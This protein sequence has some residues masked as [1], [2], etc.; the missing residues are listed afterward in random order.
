MYESLFKLGVGTN[1]IEGEAW[2]I[3]REKMSGP[4]GDR[5]V[6][7]TRKCEMQRWT[8]SEVR[9]KA[10][11]SLNQCWR[12]E[13]LVRRLVGL[14]RKIVR[15]QWMK[16]KSKLKEVM[17]SIGTTQD[18]RT[19]SQA[20]AEV[21]TTRREEWKR[22]QPKHL[23]KVDHLLV[24]AKNCQK[25]NMC[26][27]LDRIWAK[28]MRINGSQSTTEMSQVLVVEKMTPEDTTMTG[29]DDQEDVVLDETERLVE[30]LLDELMREK[31]TAREERARAHHVED[32][33]LEDVDA[34]DN[35]D[36]GTGVFEA[37]T[38]CVVDHDTT[39]NKL[40]MTTKTE[41]RDKYLS[42]E[43]N[44]K[45]VQ[46]ECDMILNTTKNFNQRLTKRMCSNNEKKADNNEEVLKTDVVKV[47]GEVNLSDAELD[48][49]SLGPG[50]M[51]VA[52]MNE[53]EMR[54]EA[55]VAL[56][57]MRWDRMKEGKEDMTVKQAKDED[58]DRSESELEEERN[59]A[60]ELERSARDV[61]DDNGESLD[62]RRRRATDMA[63]NRRVIMPPPGRPLL[64]NFDLTIRY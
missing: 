35:D 1:N 21:Q 61:L 30:T 52:K 57:K 9:E 54:T 63:G 14:R 47:F 8:E 18:K 58:R 50:F 56:T 59:L 42:R 31:K 11:C 2:K 10:D 53:V 25:H 62:M 15:D 39:N 43:D 41:I 12:D 16:S 32:E 55:T 20:W 34:E 27:D 22:H 28:R 5:H 60:E 33:L 36:T 19:L 24:R 23:V 17:K 51:V 37:V 45:I 40:D 49:L 38:D 26:R 29:G 6:M 13:R 46:N 7:E 3:Q 4:M 64:C 44:L 48:L